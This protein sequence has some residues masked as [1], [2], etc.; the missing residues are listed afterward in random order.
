L[1][2][3]FF[4]DSF[5]EGDLVFA[6]AV[7]YIPWPGIIMTKESLH[8]MVNFLGSDDTRRIEN[9]KIWPYSESNKEKYITSLNLE[10]IEFRDAILIAEKLSFKVDGNKE[11]GA[12]NYR[13]LSQ[14][15]LQELQEQ[16]KDSQE[17]AKQDEA[18][19]KKPSQNETNEEEL[20]KDETEE[21]PGKEPPGVAEPGEEGPDMEEPTQEADNLEEEMIKYVQALRSDH[22]SLNDGIELKFIQLVNLLRHSLR[23]NQKD[24]PSALFALEEL[25]G[26]TFSEL[27]LVRNFEAVN[28]IYHICYLD[29]AH[30]NYSEA[31][32]VQLSAKQLIFRFAPLIRLS[33]PMEHFM[34]QFRSLSSIYRRFV[35]ELN[36]TPRRSSEEESWQGAV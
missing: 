35:S 33:V 14:S 16:E 6:K 21:D 4:P 3:S 13:V 25:H 24:Y 8:S 2:T 10:Y 5:S 27:L 32:E 31:A 28:S 12:Y 7:G 1:F 11:N 30:R 9:S 26:M 34:D 20:D 36:P 15:D 18:K 22:K 29:T 23:T 19:A 17:V